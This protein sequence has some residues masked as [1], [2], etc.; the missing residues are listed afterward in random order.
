MSCI[1]KK[2]RY[3]REAKLEA[4][5][6]VEPLSYAFLNKESE[7]KKSRPI[8]K[9]GKTLSRFIMDSSLVR[10]ISS[11]KSQRAEVERALKVN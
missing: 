3:Y 6:V 4:V 5:D 11:L 10:H 9:N 8:A 2:S 7:V 1:Y